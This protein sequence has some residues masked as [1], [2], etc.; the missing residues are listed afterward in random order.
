MLF[1]LNSCLTS[2]FPFY[3]SLILYLHPRDIESKT[4]LQKLD[5][6]D[7]PE[8]LQWCVQLFSLKEAV[9]KLQSCCNSSIHTDQSASC[10]SVTDKNTIHL[11]D[12]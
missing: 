11:R 7:S 8:T 3:T 12:H 9:D 1:K 2:Y 5:V 6:F 10:M 4:T